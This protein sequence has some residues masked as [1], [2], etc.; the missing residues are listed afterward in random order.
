MTIQKKGIRAFKEVKFMRGCFVKTQSHSQLLQIEKKVQFSIQSPVKQVP[1]ASEY[2]DPEWESDAEP[3]CAELDE[4]ICPDYRSL[5]FS[6]ALSEELRVPSAPSCFDRGNSVHRSRVISW[7]IRATSEMQFLDETL[8]LAVA[9]FDRVVAVDSI[10]TNSLQLY[11]S[12]CLLIASKMEEK[13][14]PVVSDFVF[15]CGC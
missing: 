13:L 11:V 2:S 9:L 8:F 10:P 15:L 5:I 6:N 12:T 7:I 1:I 4:S 14:T 3:V